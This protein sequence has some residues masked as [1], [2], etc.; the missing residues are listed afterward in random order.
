MFR[1]LN[2]L[3]VAIK[4]LLNHGGRPFRINQMPRRVELLAWT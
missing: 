2:N 4:T 3:A 1:I